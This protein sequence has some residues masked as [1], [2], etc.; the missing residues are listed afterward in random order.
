[1]GRTRFGKF[2]GLGKLKRF[3]AEK[4]FFLFYSTLGIKPTS[5]MV[6]FIKIIY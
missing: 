1:L 5:A 6:T 4:A 3:I 2:S